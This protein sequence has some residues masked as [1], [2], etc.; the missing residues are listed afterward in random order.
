MRR[1]LLVSILLLA[2][3]LATAAR[4]TIDELK[5]RRVLDD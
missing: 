4:P 2:L 5:A 1:Q 3:P